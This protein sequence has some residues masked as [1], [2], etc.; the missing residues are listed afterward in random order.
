MHIIKVFIHTNANE[1]F[2]ASVFIKK[3]GKN[4]VEFGFYFYFFGKNI[5]KICGILTFLKKLFKLI[6]LNVVIIRRVLF[7][8]DL[9]NG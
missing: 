1:C 5:E 6:M 8:L 9:N 2:Y 3:K 7:N 4:R